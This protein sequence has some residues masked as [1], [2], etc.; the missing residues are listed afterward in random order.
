LAKADYE[1]YEI[2]NFAKS[3]YRSKHNASYWKGIPY[4]G[5]G[6]AA[7]SYN[8]KTRRWNVAN[9]TQYVKGVLQNFPFWEEENLTIYDQYNEFVMTGLRKMEGISLNE[10]ETN[11]GSEI[12][13]HLQSASAHLLKTGR[14]VLR[15]NR[16][17]IP[18]REWFLADTLI[19][20][21]FWV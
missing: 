17:C 20:E 5:I 2:S 15:K 9:N 3:G 18:E 14:L 19:S 11:F 21:L 8:G 6:P 7:H 16:L 1:H 12:L 4:L 13:H 10:M